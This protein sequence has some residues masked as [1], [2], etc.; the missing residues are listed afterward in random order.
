MKIIEET[1][2]LRFKFILE[3][4]NWKYNI[5]FPVTINEKRKDPIIVFLN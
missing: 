3:F 5:G 4:Y 1:Q 2:T